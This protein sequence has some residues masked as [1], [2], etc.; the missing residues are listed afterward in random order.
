MK[1]MKQLEEVYD[2]IKINP[3]LYGYS[4]KVYIFCLKLLF[5]TRNEN[6]KLYSKGV[7]ISI[8][9]LKIRS[10]NREKQHKI[11]CSNVRYHIEDTEFKILK[12]KTKLSR[13]SKENGT[14]CL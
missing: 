9:V 14:H 11:M 13:V 6:L 8:L 10:R 7:I 4:M 5:V 2:L 1:L 3:I 12:F